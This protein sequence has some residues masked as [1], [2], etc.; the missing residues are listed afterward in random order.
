MLFKK[1]H[2]AQKGK[3]GVEA[4]EEAGLGCGAGK[5]VT[6]VDGG[7]RTSPPHRSLRAL[8]ML[9]QGGAGVGYLPT[10]NAKVLR[11]EKLFLS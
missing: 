11:A 8:R 6:W 9:E 3:S 1:R 2:K 10:S 7:L 4:L 5:L